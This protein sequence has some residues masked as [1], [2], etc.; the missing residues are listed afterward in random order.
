LTD[1]T[2]AP[3]GQTAGTRAWA[4]GFAVVGLLYSISTGVWLMLWGNAQ[5]SLHLSQQS[6]SNTILLGILAAFGLAPFAASTLQSL[7]A[8][9]KP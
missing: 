1:E 3:V 9:K 2:I 4:V 8:G 5:N 6:W 7:I